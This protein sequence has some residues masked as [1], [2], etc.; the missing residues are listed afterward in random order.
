MIK[1]K[2]KNKENTVVI[3]ILSAHQTWP[4][5]HI[6]VPILSLTSGINTFSH[7]FDFFIFTCYSYYLLYILLSNIE[8]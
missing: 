5:L 3:E 2:Y 6:Q 8:Y 1:I 7:I 4:V